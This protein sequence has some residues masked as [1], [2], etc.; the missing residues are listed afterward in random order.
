MENQGGFC[1]I[2][3]R[4]LISEFA[5]QNSGG[6]FRRSKTRRFHGLTQF[7]H[8]GA[9]LLPSRNSLCAAQMELRPPQKTSP[10]PKRLRSSVRK[11]QPSVVSSTSV[12]AKKNGGQLSAATGKCI[13]IVAGQV[14]LHPPETQA[15]HISSGLIHLSIQQICLFFIH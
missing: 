12:P 14:R 5:R 6:S 15:S 8:P 7:R 13:P 9:R 3:E 2:F 4:R 10:S 11:N 1:L